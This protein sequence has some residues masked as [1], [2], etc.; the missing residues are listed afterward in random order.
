MTTP[1]PPAGVEPRAEQVDTRG[2]FRPDLVKCGQ[3][4]RPPNGSS[5]LVHK[6]TVVKVPHRGF[7]TI[8]RGP[9]C[10]R[11]TDSKRC[12]PV[13]LRPHGALVM[14]LTVRTQASRRHRV[15]VWEKSPKGEG[16]TEF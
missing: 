10:G 6:T 12:V 15:P 2:S 7:V 16:P 1:L 14:A 13:G 9:A 5:F 8:K 3:S 11:L 4:S